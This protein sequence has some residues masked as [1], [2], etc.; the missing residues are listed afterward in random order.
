MAG[1]VHA[2]A[3][4]KKAVRHRAATLPHL[5]LMPLST[6]LALL[7]QVDYR[8]S[9]LASGAAK[10]GRPAVPLESLPPE[11]IAAMQGLALRHER[12]RW[13]HLAA[14]DYTLDIGHHWLWGVVILAL[15]YAGKL[16]CWQQTGWL[17]VRDNNK[18]DVQDKN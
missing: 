4:A 16:L 7:P 15:D 1:A 3:T 10:A 6:A 12:Y 17:D 9:V 11:A 8:L 5:R 13:Q 2:R 18:E 14:E